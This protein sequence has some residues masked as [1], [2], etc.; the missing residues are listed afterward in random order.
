MKKN[1]LL[2]TCMLFFA[3]LAQAQTAEE[4]IEKYLKAIGGKEKWLELKNIKATGK[5]KQGQM[6]FPFTQ[7]QATGGKQKTSFVFQG[8]EMTQPAFDGNVGW[9]T[10][11]MTM[12]AEK[13]ETEDAEN[14][15]R[16]GVDFPDPFIDYAKKGYKI[17]LEG[18]E[19][20]EGTECFKIKLTKKTTLVDGKEEENVV[21]YFF[22]TE[23]FVPLVSRTVGKKGQMKGLNMETVYSD[24]QE[25]NGL[26]F[27]FTIAQ[28]MNGQVGFTIVIEKVELN[29][30][31]DD[32]MFAFPTEEA[33]K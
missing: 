8:K 18:K 14:M 25:V 19:K 7:I 26:Y 4:I 20:V 15:K 16:E 28:K 23:N 30:A 17:A 22:D 27:P 24:Y 12:K 2:A 3:T 5:G 13:M 31:L 9:S 10:N 11:F 21:Y 29:V 32:K 33:K 6:E 1:L